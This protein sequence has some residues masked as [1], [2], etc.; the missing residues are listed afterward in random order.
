MPIFS[1]SLTIVLTPTPSARWIHPPPLLRL[2]SLS[3]SSV[4]LAENVLTS[5]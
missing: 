3:I 2:T 1:L 4:M 5:L